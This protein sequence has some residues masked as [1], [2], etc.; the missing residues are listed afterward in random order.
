M[1]YAEVNLKDYFWLCFGEGRKMRHLINDKMN[2]IHLCV[3]TYT[4]YIHMSMCD[5]PRSILYTIGYIQ[6][7]HIHTYTTVNIIRI[8]VWH[9]GEDTSPDAHSVH[10]IHINVARYS[11]MCSEWCLVFYLFRSIS[12]HISYYV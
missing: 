9:R 6:I 2:N 5:S 12:A 11:H 4:Y 10:L 1:S 3:Q 8:Y 7:H